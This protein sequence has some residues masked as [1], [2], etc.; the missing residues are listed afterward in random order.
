VLEFFRIPNADEL[1]AAYI[2]KETKS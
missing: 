1:I 2:E